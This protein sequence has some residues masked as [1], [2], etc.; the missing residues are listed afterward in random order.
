MNKIEKLV[1][2]LPNN[3]DAVLITSGIN[4]F[5]YTNFHSSAGI[6]LITRKASYFFIDFRYIE[7]ARKTIT[8]CEVSLLQNQKQ[9]LLDIIKAENIK[10]LALESGYITLKDANFYKTILA[11]TEIIFDDRVTSLIQKQRSIK[12]ADEIENIKVAQQV[13]DAGFSYILDKI[14][15]GKTE[16]EI[17][18]D[19]E[20]F[21]R[22]NGVSDKSFD[23]IVVSGKNSSLPHGV[24]S[25][26]KIEKGDFV[27][28]DF[29]G[30]YGGYCSDMTRT[31][32]V[33]EPSEKQ[34]E[35]YNLVLKAQTEAIKSLAPNVRCSS[36][37][38]IARD[39]IYNAGYKG[40]FGHGL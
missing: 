17:A 22:K 9:Q 38:K 10:T 31:V 26:K 39:I 36:V 18:L 13:T 5:Y 20:F 8:N 33:G 7:A 34:K 12:T 16:K 35:V 32:A 14:S 4:R 23:F 1:Q 29:G 30:I 15:V 2:N 6:L 19:L 40:C 11:P 28:M 3:I 37:D 24:P 25:D 27:T 21:M